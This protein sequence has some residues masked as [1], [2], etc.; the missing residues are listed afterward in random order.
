MSG[1]AT[2]VLETRPKALVIPD[3]SLDQFNR[4]SCIRVVNGRTVNTPVKL[5]RANY[6]QGWEVLEGLNES[7][8]VIDFGDRGQWVRPR[9]AFEDGTRVEIVP[10]DRNEPKRSPR[11][12]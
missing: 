1:Q 10:I 2:I 11:Q 4:F 12:R 6:R 9:P 8:E 5:G 7:D 3:G